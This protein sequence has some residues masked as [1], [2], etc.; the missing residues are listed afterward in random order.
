MQMIAT[1]ELRQADVAFQANLYADPNPT[2]RG[3]HLAR[4]QWIESALARYLPLQGSAIEVG[5][6]CGVFV[7]YL[8]LLGARVTA[9]DINPAFLAD[10]AGV[11]NVETVLGDATCPL[12]LEQHDIVLCSEV[13]EHVPPTR[14]LGM[15]KSLHAVLKPGGHLVLTTPQRYSAMEL[16]ARA[17]RFPWILRLARRLYGS[18]DELGHINLLTAGQ[19]SSLLRQSGFEV[20]HEVRIGLYLPVLAEFG[21]ETGHR[22]L[23]AIGLK[24]ERFPVVKHLLWTQAYVLRRAD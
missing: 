16:A 10:V 14:S 21:G 19:L 9:L 8:S 5:I 11:A 3:L 4:R 23:Q 2:R 12:D 17:L 20:E 15:L 22:V 7:R 24:F 6:G 1:H 18:A 13:L